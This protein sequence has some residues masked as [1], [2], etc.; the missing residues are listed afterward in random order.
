MYQ[1]VKRVLKHFFIYGQ[2]D[3]FVLIIKSE[4]KII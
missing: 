3:L 1:G 4:F 2:K